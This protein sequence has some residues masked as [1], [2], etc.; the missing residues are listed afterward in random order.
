[1]HQGNDMKDKKS[2]TTVDIHRYERQEILHDWGFSGNTKF[3]ERR[4]IIL[5]TKTIKGG[6]QTVAC[7]WGWGGGGVH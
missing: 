2:F 4:S 1:M 7:Q 5:S 6:L 3:S